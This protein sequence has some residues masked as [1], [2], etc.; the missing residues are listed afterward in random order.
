M[1]GNASAGHR[2]TPRTTWG[3][4]GSTSHSTYDSGADTR[5]YTGGVSA[6][7]AATERTSIDA[8]AGMTFLTDTSVAGV[9]DHERSPSGSLSIRYRDRGFSAVLTGSYE[10][11]GGG[12]F[13]QG[14]E[15]A[16]VGLSLNGQVTPRWS[17]D[18]VGSYQDE[19]SAGPQSTRSVSTA[20]GT[21]GVRYAAADW[22]A[23]R[24]AGYTFKQWNQEEGADIARS[25]ILLGLTLSDT[26][27]LF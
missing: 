19:R 3:I 15:R 10:L 8:R 7:Y 14:T 11:T 24:L 9:V 25:H 16:N 13:G 4:F 22:A 17:W 27:L 26:Y 5:A 20:N 1:T 2:I 21:A 18:L 6:S 23:F 12:S